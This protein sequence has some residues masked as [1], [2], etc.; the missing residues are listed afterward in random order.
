MRRLAEIP[1]KLSR[2]GQKL[3]VLEV[4]RHAARTSF[5]A[6][7]RSTKQ[8]RRCISAIV[9]AQE[10][11]QAVAQSVQDRVHQHLAT[12]VSRC[13]EAVFERPYR[14]RIIFERKRGRTG[15]RLVFERN[16][17]EVDPMT[18]SGGGVVDVA[19]FALRIACLMIRR[20]PLRRILILDEPFKSPS[21]HYRERVRMLMEEL[22][23]ELAVQF[24]IVTN[25][26]ELAAG[27]IVDLSLRPIR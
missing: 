26:D 14:F 9:E 23:E 2:F 27:K 12:V 18:S 11:A 25:I 24:I 16:G 5:Q 13:L 6:A 20:P 15:A 1:S 19:S 7:R 22:S 21:P 8:A 10:V 3:A 17:L 4:N